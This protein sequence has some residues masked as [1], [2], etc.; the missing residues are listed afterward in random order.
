M[1]FQY[2]CE[3]FVLRSEGPPLICHQSSSSSSTGYLYYYHL[4][5]W[6]KQEDNLFLRTERNPRK[7]SL[8]FHILVGRGEIDTVDIKTQSLKIDSVSISLH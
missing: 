7:F 1:N 8:L 4:Q 5:Q 6:L 2:F 3:I